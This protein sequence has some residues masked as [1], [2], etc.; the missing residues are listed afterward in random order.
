[1]KT[2]RLSRASVAIAAIAATFVAV[3]AQHGAASADASLSEHMHRHMSSIRAV[4]QFIIAGQIDGM[5]E[6]AVW[7]AEHE[8][9]SDL[10]AGWEPYVTELRQHA[11]DTAF[12]NHLVFAAASLSEMARTCGDCHRANNVS[13]VVDDATRPAPEGDSVRVQMRRHLWAADRMWE[14]LIG[15]SDNAWNDGIGVLASVDVESADIGALPEQEPKV[16]YLLTRVREL[17]EL[18]GEADSSETRSAVYGEFLSLCADCHSWTGG[19][20]AVP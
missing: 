18:G 2:C 1:M 9:A 8:P 20:P 13:G 14:G 5:R 11:L 7:L 12:A 17:G 16:D 3:A 19:G 6:P 15:P 4:K 10:P